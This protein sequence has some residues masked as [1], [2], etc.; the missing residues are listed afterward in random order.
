MLKLI[1]DLFLRLSTITNADRIVV[2]DKGQIV[3]SGTHQELLDLKKMYYKLVS[4]DNA[5]KDKNS[6]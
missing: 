2:L 6:K 3:E 5:G 1:Y 4:S